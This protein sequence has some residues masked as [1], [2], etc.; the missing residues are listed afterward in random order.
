MNGYKEV[1]STKISI[2]NHQK[3]LYPDWNQSD[4][5]STPKIDNC[6]NSFLTSPSAMNSTCI[7]GLLSLVNVISMCQWKSKNN[8]FKDM[9]PYRKPYRQATAPSPSLELDSIKYLHKK[10]NS[11]FINASSSKPSPNDKQRREVSKFKFS[12]A[13]VGIVLHS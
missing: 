13:D 6:K 11:N 9:K 2:T 5:V 3:M 12:L 8:A 7:E 1:P 4:E 10:F